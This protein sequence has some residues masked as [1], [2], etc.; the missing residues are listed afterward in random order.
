M[1]AMIPNVDGVGDALGRYT[2]I[3]RTADYNLRTLCSGSSSGNLCP[4]PSL[5]VTW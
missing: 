5:A 4:S 3:D 2:T 1:T